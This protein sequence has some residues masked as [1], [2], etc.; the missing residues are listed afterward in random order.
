[1]TE[2]SQ[3]E[4]SLLRLSTV[5]HSPHERTEF[6]RFPWKCGCSNVRAQTVSLHHKHRKVDVELGSFCLDQSE[7]L[8]SA[9]MMF[10]HEGS[11]W[12]CKRWFWSSVSLLISSSNIALSFSSFRFQTDTVCRRHADVYPWSWTA[13]KA[14]CNKRMD[15]SRDRPVSPAPLSYCC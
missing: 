9:Q 10:V 3:L 13:T 6:G 7:L 5:N 1:M 14:Q 8:S 2:E 11:N 15:V 12:S 4:V